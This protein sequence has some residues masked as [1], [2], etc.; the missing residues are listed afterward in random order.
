MTVIVIA[1]LAAARLV[2]LA[3]SAW[4]WAAARRQDLLTAG[5]RVA[6]RPHMPWLPGTRQTPIARVWYVAAA[7]VA[8]R[9]VGCAGTA[10]HRVSCCR[11]RH[12][13][14]GCHSR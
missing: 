1:L 14:E 8:L 9:H 7:R 5:R 3:A 13:G 12:P 11:G 4:R 2:V 6:D 10:G